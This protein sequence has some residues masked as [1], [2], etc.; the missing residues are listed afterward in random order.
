MN[1]LLNSLMSAAA[2]ALGTLSPGKG[3]ESHGQAAGSGDFAALL[4]G[5]LAPDVGGETIA[6]ADGAEGGELL[7]FASHGELLSSDLGAA[8]AVSAASGG[9]KPP[10]AAA[11]AAHAAALPA[12]AEA[13]RSA[14]IAAMLDRALLEAAVADGP[15]GTA[16]ASGPYRGMDRLT[17]E[18]RARFDRV[19][20]R[21]AS[22]H[23][24]RV[25]VVETWRDPSR[26]EALYQQGRT[27]PG[28]VVTWT[29][30]SNHL[31][32]RAADVKID[33]GYDDTAA[34]VRLARIAQEEGLRTLGP[35]DPGHVELSRPGA[36]AA[37]A[38]PAGQPKV[39]VAGGMAQVARVADVAQVAQVARVAAVAQPG[40]VVPQTRVSSAP[41]LHIR[42]AEPEATSAAAPPPSLPAITI[43]TLAQPSDASSQ[44]G[45]SDGTAAAEAAE[46]TLRERGEEAA[47]AEGA[48][49]GESG[50]GTPGVGES[51]SATRGAVQQ[52]SAAGP[53]A[54]AAAAERVARVL[55]IQ[56]DLSTRPMSS[57]LLRVESP[58]GVEDRIRVDLRGSGVETTLDLGSMADANRLGA[59]VEDL[60]RAL[61]RHG[62]DA[63]VVRIRSTGST[64]VAEAARV[65]S[66]LS[67]SELIRA[68]N[69]RQ[70]SDSGFSRDG[71]DGTAKDESRSRPDG[72]NHRSRKEHNEEKGK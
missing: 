27:A 5:A 35:M 20:E 71:G 33:G 2:S 34:F 60:S 30:N 59:R 39:E 66:M 69:A 56:A 52:T 55:D 61:E 29:R 47:A 1:V 44:Q 18:F 19:V 21:M 62:L 3:G 51:R 48:F 43:P 4:A 41:R 12:G 70:T 25:E 10:A 36:S 38:G 28:P 14:E 42:A 50:T 45:W 67:E 63:D 58:T 17:G 68:G 32:G 46:P 23:G 22:E 31:S 9:S 37:A 8:L 26:Q 6:V 54:G 15:T 24:H 53:T 72:G 65:A 16:P 11:T 57:M 7:E 49:A 13:V 40:R 64:D